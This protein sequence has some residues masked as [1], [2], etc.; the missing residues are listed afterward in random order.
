M[1]GARLRCL[2]IHGSRREFESRGFDNQPGPPQV[3]HGAICAGETVVA[4]RL[5]GRPP[6]MSAPLHQRVGT[7][8]DR[9]RSRLHTVP[10][11]AMRDTAHRRRSNGAGRSSDH[12]LSQTARRPLASGPRRQHAVPGGE[13]RAPVRGR[14]RAGGAAKAVRCE[15][16][17]KR[18]RRP[19]F[20]GRRGKS[21]NAFDDRGGVLLLH[22]LDST[23]QALLS[24]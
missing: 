5:L 17:P 15:A 14:A 16:T 7:G 11:L 20:D 4:D 19:S 12:H 9:R 13:R 8:R 21:R 6:T 10:G 23:S 22:R 24:T 1:R 18:P 2:G 3:L